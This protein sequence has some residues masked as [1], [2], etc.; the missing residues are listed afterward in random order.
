MA[1]GAFPF[2]G[3]V[4][5]AALRMELTP[6]VTVPRP[7]ARDLTHDQRRALLD[8][9]DANGA[10][11]HGQRVVTVELLTVDA[12]MIA[13]TRNLTDDTGRAFADPISGLV[14]TETTDHLLRVPPP[15][16]W[17]PRQSA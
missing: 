17:Q 13:V 2:P 10:P 3:E 12:P 5:H 7:E 14:A 1:L 15:E 4:R 9:L 6:V 11:A 8:W 16:F